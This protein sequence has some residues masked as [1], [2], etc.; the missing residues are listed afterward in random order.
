MTTPRAPALGATPVTGGTRFAVW[1][2]GATKLWLCLFDARGEAELDRIPLERGP[3]GVFAAT[4]P[5]IGAGARYGLRAD[6]PYDPD[7]GLWFDPSKLLVDPHA[8]TLDR[9]FAWDPVIAAPRGTGIDSA[10]FVPKA[11]VTPLPAPRPPEAPRFRPGGLIYELQVRAFT[12]L[13]PAVPE[14]IRGTVAALAHPAVLDH[15]TRIGVDAVELMP[16]T[17]WIDERHLAALG[18]RNAWGYNPVV[19]LAPEPRICPGG[20]AELAAAVTALHGAGIGV[21]L[22]VVYNHTGEG[23]RAGSVLSLRGLDAQAY[24]RHHEGGHLVNDTGTGNTLDCSHPATRRLVLDAMRHFVGQA[25]IDGF[26]FDLAPILGRNGHGFDPDAALLREIA[27]DP[28]LGTRVLI[29]EPWDIGPGG[30]AL[31]RFPAPWL[32]WNDRFRDRVRSFWQGTPNG[33]GDFA[34][35]LAGSGDVFPPPQTRTVNF[36][37]A[38]D[39]FTLADLVSYDEKHNEANGEA[40]RDGHGTNHSW[41]H[42]VEGPSDDPMV[43]TA[44]RRDMRALLATLFASRGTIMLT[45]G[46]EF[47]R[48]QSGNNNAY[49]QDNETTWL[50]WEGRDTELEAFTAA[51][52]AFRRARPALSDP[53]L[54]TGEPE[55]NGLPDVAWLTAGGK[56][57]ATADWE[58]H[59]CDA[60]AMVL[61]RGGDGRLAVLFNR[62]ASEVAF[63]LPTRPGHAWPDARRGRIAVAPRS[64]AFAAE[65]PTGKPKP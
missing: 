7:R 24:F 4:V 30:Y 38:H 16:V 14:A 11:I 6:G 29:A 44:R 33:P 53:V 35:A 39:G 13:H 43:R 41:N 57:K 47:G 49:A 25:G 48:S 37:A 5:G 22:D 23:E 63:R 52:A 21:I 61:A 42:G 19:F 60:F 17:A 2:G 20:M 10:P 12:R 26:R 56:R 55:P 28:W 59:R 64:V 50:D 65:I 54:L 45:A 9:S 3:D 62:T 32:E 58:G 34:T 1:S 36:V 8:V 15:L 46:D 51:L 18:L 40:N 31:G 27:A